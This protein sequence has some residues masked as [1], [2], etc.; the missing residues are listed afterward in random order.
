M[1]QRSFFAGLALVAIA[2]SA[3]VAQSRIYRTSSSGAGFNDNPGSRGGMTAGAT[4]NQ[5][6]MVINA[7]SGGAGSEAQ[8]RSMPGGQ[9]AATAP[10]NAQQN[11]RGSANRPTFITIDPERERFERERE[12]NRD[13]RDHVIQPIYYPYYVYPP[14]DTPYYTDE[15]QQPAQQ[16]AEPETPAPTIFENRPGYQAPPVR[17]AVISR[18]PTCDGNVSPRPHTR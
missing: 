8:A 13:R 3:A 5:R 12:R 9:P 11:P 18:P 16:P 4:S 14:S 2:A 1:R 6:G 10:G 7:G 17:A 15:Q